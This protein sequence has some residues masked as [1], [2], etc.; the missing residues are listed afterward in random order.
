[1]VLPKGDYCNEEITWFREVFDEHYEGIRNYAFFKTGDAQLADDVVQDTFLK[2]WSL[3]ERV[4][5]GTVKAL[6]YTIASNI[7]KNQFKHSKVVYK[8]SRLIPSNPTAESADSPMLTSEFQSELENAIAQIPENARVVFLMSRIEE[9]NYNEIAD[10]LNL[11]IKAIE[12][13]MSEALKILRSRL[14][15]KL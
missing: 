8:F 7:I 4:R 14:S 2:V 9:L 1:L 10:R 15:Y 11:S 3:K 6:L 5:R 13:R 12:K